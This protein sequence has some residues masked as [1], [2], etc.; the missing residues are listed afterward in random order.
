LYVSTVS[1]GLASEGEDW[2]RERRPGLQ[3]A[4][5]REKTWHCCHEV[6]LRATQGGGPNVTIDVMGLVVELR[7]AQ[8]GGA[9][10]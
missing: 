10:T 8:G 4:A 9:Q 2:P 6:V 5:S 1:R 7:A 3:G